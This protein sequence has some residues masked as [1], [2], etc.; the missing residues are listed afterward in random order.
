MAILKMGGEHIVISRFRSILAEDPIL[1]ATAQ[2]REE[3]AHI[4]FL[5]SGLVDSER[6]DCLDLFIRRV[7]TNVDELL[8]LQTPEQFKAYYV[9]KVQEREIAK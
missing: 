9:K 5:V 8:R 6:K 7:I 3:M 4:K 1:Y 2:S